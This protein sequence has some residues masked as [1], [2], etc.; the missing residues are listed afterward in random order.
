LLAI[1]AL[2]PSAQGVFR[3]LD[4]AL[5]RWVNGLGSPALD[6]FVTAFNGGNLFKRLAIAAAV[7][8][9]WKGG[10]KG[11]VCLLFLGLTLAIGDALVCSTIKKA[12]ARPRPFAQLED[13]RNVAGQGRSA[14]MPSSHAANSMAIAIVIGMFYRRSRY[15]VYPVAAMVSF[16]RVYSGVHFPSDVLV[17]A[18]LAA[19]YAPAILYGAEWFWKRK[20]AEWAPALAAKI[21]SLLNVENAPS[22][23]EFAP[24]QT[25]QAAEPASAGKPD[26]AWMKLGWALLGFTLIFRLWYL[27]AGKID[28]SEDEAYQWMWSKH[29][30]LSYYSK[31]P[32][33]A[34]AQFLGSSIGG[35]T[36][37]GVRM[38]SPILAAFTA[39]LMMIFVRRVANPRAAFFTMLAG[40]AT[41]ILAVGATLMTIDILLVTFWTLA[42]WFVWQAVQRD[43]TKDWALAGVAIAF[44]LLAKYAALFQWVSVVLFLAFYPPARR[45][46]RRHGFYLAI[47]IS[48]L[49][50][51]PV[52]IW[53]EQHGWI[54]LTHLNERAGLN[55]AWKLT[56]RY[57]FDFTFSE[58]GLL[59]PVFV[60]L[61]VWA[62]KRLWKNLPPAQI[63]L[64]AMGVPL[65]IGYFL[66]SLRSRVQPNWIAPGILPVFALAAIYWEAQW[67]TARRWLKPTLQWGFGF[68]LAISLL[69][70][71]T[72]LT[73]KLFGFTLPANLDP[74]RRVRGWSEMARLIAEERAKSGAQF[75]ICGHYGSTSLATFYTPETRQAPAAHDSIYVVAT[76]RPQN[77]YYFW[78]NYLNRSGEDALLVLRAGWAVPEEI[79]AQFESI[80]SLGQRP[81]L[82]RGREFHQLE[83]YH[84][85]N[86]RPQPPRPQ[87][88]AAYAAE[89]RLA[90]SR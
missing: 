24:L 36:E 89:R 54:T 88:E 8:L 13:V 48:L 20:G 82:Y 70:H 58:F 61:I 19:I 46:F 10:R 77:Q 79:K 50:L 81:V 33:I 43:S 27:G 86:L 53:N 52:I 62:I 12:V 32:L 55:N 3:E 38:L 22:S 63:F 69:L 85:R 4:V 60:V 68:G 31:P 25:R 21:P 41:P 11:R 44:G 73:E 28:L 87:A 30:A 83:F 90:I 18:A 37:F 2:A 42:M 26:V 71:D 78:P 56:T 64:L 67:P 80:E 76:D 40:F 47:A 15:V 74:L 17:G 39:G 34:Y 59:N 5:F 45:Q 65:F 35:N 23:V 66:F 29:L 6:P 9:A 14:S 16:A 7:L 57:V 49:A 1:R 75:V 84:C 72:N 51:L